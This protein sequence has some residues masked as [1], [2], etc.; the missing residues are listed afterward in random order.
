MLAPEAKPRIPSPWRIRNDTVHTLVYRC[1][2]DQL[3]FKVCSPIEASIVPF[4]GG[5]FTREQ[6]L[7]AWG[8][9]V[10]QAGLVDR[11]LSPLFDGAYNALSE[12]GLVGTEGAAS[13]SFRD[14]DGG[15]LFPNFGAYRRSPRRLQRPIAVNVAMT[16]RCTCDCV[17]CYA[18]RRKVGDASLEQLRALFDELAANE[19]FVVD[20]VGGDLFT[21][22][23]A[24]AILEEMV[25]REFVFFLSTKS[26]LSRRQAQRL[27]E[28]GI[29]VPDSPPH[30]R[31]IVQVSVD[32]VDRAMASRLTRSAQFAE[33]TADTVV[34]L[35][36]AGLAPRVKCVLTGLNH[37]VAGELVERF[38]GLGVK[39]FQL[40][41]YGRSHYRHRDELFLSREQKL[42]VREAVERLRCSHPELSIEY[43]DVDGDGPMARK[44]PEEWQAR[45]LCS[46]GRISML[47]Q[48]NG[49]VTLCDQVPHAAPFVVGNVFRESMMDVW[50]SPRL[51]SFLYPERQRFAEAP[52]ATCPDFDRCH[53]DYGYCY[54]DALFHYGSP[55]DAP[56]DCPRQ[57][58]PPLRAV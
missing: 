25:Q 17:Y 4:L 26:H 58:K 37:A 27:R 10:R 57:H 29:G 6:I 51:E 13:P 30:L 9:A 15:R 35:V 16:N 11:P 34:N 45:A 5:E 2:T 54:R 43:Q 7:E 23:D 42:Q 19:V 48:P 12:A 8:T 52:C 55:Y 28:L 33:R 44:T 46:G 24:L 41:Q 36:S 22:N 50:R 53:D 49:D 56:P 32:A 3:S 31:R 18:E 39:A 1:A 40:V 38:A 20:V 21:R 14:D 47:V